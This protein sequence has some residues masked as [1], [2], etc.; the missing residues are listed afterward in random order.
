MSDAGTVTAALVI[1]GN[2]ILSGRTQDLNMAYLGKGLNEVGV[3]LREVRVVPDVEDTIVETVNALRAAHD[4]VF[5]TGGIGP[6]HDDITAASV[7]KAFGVKVVRDPEARRRLE[8]HY[9]DSDIELNESRLKMADVPEGAALIDNPVSGAP[10]F[11]VG[12]VYVM[13]GVPRIMQAM[14]DGFKHTLKGGAE[15][16]SRTVIAPIGEGTVAK[17]LGDIQAAHPGVDIGSYPFYGGGR[18][19]TSLVTRGTDVAEV[20]AVADEIRALIRSLGHEPGDP[21]E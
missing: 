9:A 15:V 19:G 21:P 16:V 10:G 20:E 7:A 18:F 4:Y 14:F 1:I 13:A 11:Q 17:G 2:E 5:T 8:S 3:Q 6:T 12:N